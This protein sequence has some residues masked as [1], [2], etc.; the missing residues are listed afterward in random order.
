MPDAGEI[1]SRQRGFEPW[2]EQVE[3][4]T[5]DNSPPL[6]VTLSKRLLSRKKKKRLYKWNVISCLGIYIY[7]LLAQDFTEALDE[8]VMTKKQLHLCRSQNRTCCA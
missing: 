1:H 6:T 2:G 7:V 8:K 4:V 5:K 3:Q